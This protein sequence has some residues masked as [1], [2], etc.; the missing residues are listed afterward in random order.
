MFCVI[1]DGP[2]VVVSGGLQTTD[3]TMENRLCQYTVQTRRTALAGGFHAGV[4]RRVR[5]GTMA[6]ELDQELLE[7]DLRVGKAAV[8]HAV[9]DQQGEVEFGAGDVD[10]EDVHEASEP[11]AWLCPCRHPCNQA[12]RRAGALDTV[13][14]R[15]G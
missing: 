1:Y 15:D 5:V 3:M 8:A 10:A 6:C 4:Q 9:A 7:A 11:V 13:Q 2:S 14:P 12:V